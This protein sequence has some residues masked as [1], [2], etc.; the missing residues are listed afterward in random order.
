MSTD[1]TVTEVFTEIDPDPDA[2]LAA[3]DADDPDA[4][5]A[6]GGEHDPSTDEAVDADDVTAADVFAD[7]QAAAHEVTGDATDRSDDRA[8]ND[9]SDDGSNLELVGP[10]PTET[11]ISS[12]AFGVGSDAGTGT[13]TSDFCWVGAGT[14][15]TRR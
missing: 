15:D 9:G 6:S 11:R 5:L 12:D 14:V 7:L 2:I 4:L 1:P 8:R 13:A 10:G 3:H